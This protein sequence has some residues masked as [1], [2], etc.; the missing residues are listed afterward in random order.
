LFAVLGFS[1]NPFV[2]E[3][4]LRISILFLLVCS[5]GPESPNSD[6]NREPLMSSLLLKA[7]F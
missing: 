5:G 2:T 6:L 7:V 4:R 1:A 3:I